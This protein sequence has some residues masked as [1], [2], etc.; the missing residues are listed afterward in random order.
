MNSNYICVY[1]FETASINPHRCQITQIGAMIL[2][3]R[4][5]KVVDTFNQECGVITDPKKLEA[6]GLDPVEQEALNVTR[7]TLEHLATMPPEKI[8]WGEFKKFI[9]KYNPTSGTYKAPIP[10]GYNIINFDLIIH[11]RAAKMYGPDSGLF[12][13][14][15]IMDGFQEFKAWTEN[16]PDV[17]SHKLS[18][19]AKFMGLPLSMLENAHDAL[20]DVKIT[21]NCMIKLMHF[22][23]SITKQTDFS[24][25]FSNNKVYVE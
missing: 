4:T 13:R 19:F 10:C 6:L 1:D 24:K 3:P 12:N 15:F 23:R 2:H 9:K 7:K 14:M 25:A 16:N 11:D 20:Q 5:L 22:K 8:V 21:A 18:D 17:V